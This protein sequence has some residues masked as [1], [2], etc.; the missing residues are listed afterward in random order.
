MFSSSHNTP[1]FQGKSKNLAILCSPMK[2]IFLG[3]QIR[4]HRFDSGTRLQ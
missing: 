1:Y 3:L 2:L 4:V